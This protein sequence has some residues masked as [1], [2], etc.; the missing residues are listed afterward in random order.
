ML[1]QS[2]ATQD[3]FSKKRKDRK[4]ITTQQEWVDKIK[5][6]AVEEEASH[7]IKT[8]CREDEVLVQSSATQEKCSKQQ[9][10][11]KHIRI[12]TINRED[13]MLAQSSAT[14]EWVDRIKTHAVEEEASSATQ[15]KSS[16]QRPDRIDITNQ[17]KKYETSCGEED[18]SNH[19]GDRSKTTTRKEEVLAPS[20]TKQDDRKEES[21]Q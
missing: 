13:E 18:S 16:K 19:Q 15:E 6:P 7:R 20:R 5:T 17:Q 9:R 11:R 1:A 10:D 3:K 8:I 21:K 12:K 14:Q 2:S 4:H